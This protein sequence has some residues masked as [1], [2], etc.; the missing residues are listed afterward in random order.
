MKNTCISKLIPDSLINTNMNVFTKVERGM[1][2]IEQLESQLKECKAQLARLGE[3]KEEVSKT[4]DQMRIQQL[5][6]DAETMRLKALIMGKCEFATIHI[7]RC[8]SSKL[9]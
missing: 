1:R 4:C 3:E 7:I 6:R 5:T 8:V 2:R 9:L